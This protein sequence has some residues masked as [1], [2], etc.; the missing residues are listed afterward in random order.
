METHLTFIV[1]PTVYLVGETSFT[2]PP[3]I[4]VNWNGEATDAER[5]AEL[6]GR[7]CY[8]S[9]NN[10]ANRTTEAYLDNIRAQ[11]HLSVFEHANFSLYIEGVSRSLTHE[12][13]RHR[14]LSPSQLSQRYVDESDVSFVVPPA[15]LAGT[16]SLLAAWQAQML[17]MRA[18]YV[19]LVDA[20]LDRH[21][22]DKVAARKVAREAARSVLPNATET[23]LIMT[24]NARAWRHFLELRAAPG[25]DA[26]IRRLAVAI[27]TVL[28]AASP[29]LFAGY[30]L[31]DG[32]LYG[33]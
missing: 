13:I 1:K 31:T 2:A 12:F 19:T 33:A 18:N 17:D 5:L 20:L 10:P 29:A 25:A 21:A 14:H 7:G 30:T 9:Y 27:Y 4:S 15:L 26:E 22:T 23:K 11:G 24:G 32:C 8:V 28:H 16:A 3:H 6:A